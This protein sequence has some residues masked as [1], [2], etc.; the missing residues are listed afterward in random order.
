MIRVV[1][2]DDHPLVRQGIRA[3]LEKSPDIQ[4][5]SE[6]Q[7]GVEAFEVVLREL[8]DVL[9]LDINMP[10]LNGIEV[11]RRIKEN[12]LPTQVLILSMYSDYSTV[13]KAFR[14]GACGYALKKVVG[15]DLPQ[16][17][18]KVSQHQF[19]VSPPLERI[20][21]S[22]NEGLVALSEDGKPLA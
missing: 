7:D 1:V 6:A 14:C 20:L 5:L 16:V 17:I 2:A 8:P 15:Q 18:Q 13:M 9:V 12:G 3:L 11:T 4:V 21:A 19:Y 10:R 22:F